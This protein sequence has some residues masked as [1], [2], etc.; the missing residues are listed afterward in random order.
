MIKTVLKDF[1][2]ARKQAFREGWNQTGFSVLF[3]TYL[4]EAAVL[5]GM[6]RK[7]SDFLHTQI[8][9]TLQIIILWCVFFTHVMYPNRLMEPMFLLPMSRE[10]KREYLKIAYLLKAAGGAILQS[11]VYFVLVLLEWISL[12]HAVLSVISLSLYS[13]VLGLQNGYGQFHLLTPDGSMGCYKREWCTKV[14]SLVVYVILLLTWDNAKSIKIVVVYMS[15]VFVQAILGIYIIKK[16]YRTQM[17]FGIEWERFYS[18]RKDS[19]ENCNQTSGHYG[20]L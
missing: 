14:Y 17:R 20:N 4:L 15:I 5:I 10:Q 3:L 18:R 7:D 6:H 9:Y 2:F 12:L 1:Y 16:D 13:L 19:D 11:V 8:V